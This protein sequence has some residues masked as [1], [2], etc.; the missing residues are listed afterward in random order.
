MKT[1]SERQAPFAPVDHP[2]RASGERWN[3]TFLKFQ[4]SSFKFQVR[5]SDLKLETWNLKLLFKAIQG[6][7][8]VVVGVEHGQ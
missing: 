3:E 5:E 6:F 1:P 8:F 7:G 4:V 2:A